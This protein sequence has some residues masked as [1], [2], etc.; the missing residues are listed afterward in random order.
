MVHIHGQLKM[1]LLAVCYTKGKERVFH[2][3]IHKSQGQR[4]ILSIAKDLFFPK[5]WSN[6][7]LRYAQDDTLP[8]A[9]VVVE[10]KE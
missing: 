3:F 2:Y 10:K 8:L 9:F 7:I 4:V 6:Q 1:P 5:H